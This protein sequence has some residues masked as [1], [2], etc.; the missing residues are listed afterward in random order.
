MWKSLDCIA[1]KQFDGTQTLLCD[2]MC[3]YCAIDALWCVQPRTNIAC[4]VTT[5][6]S[7]MAPDQTPPAQ[8]L[9]QLSVMAIPLISRNMWCMIRP[10]QRLLGHLLF[11]VRCV[12]LHGK[13]SSRMLGYQHMAE[14]IDPSD[15]ARLRSQVS[16]S[17][18]A[19]DV[20]VLS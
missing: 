1:S 19:R 9:Y 3:F 16:S 4:V 5:Y 2:T 18:L 10:Y 12:A 13:I 20:S 14:C 8:I 6:I 15:V 7:K 17:Q 11:C